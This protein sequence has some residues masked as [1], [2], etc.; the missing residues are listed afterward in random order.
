MAIYYITLPVL[1]T[2]DWIVFAGVNCPAM[3]LLVFQVIW[4]DKFAYAWANWYF[5]FVAYLL[6]TVYIL[7]Q[8]LLIMELK[9]TIS[10]GEIR[11]RTNSVGD[12][13]GPTLVNDSNLSEANAEFVHRGL[14]ALPKRYFDI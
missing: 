7:M 10:N 12:P 8:T 14:E 3:T 5:S 6:G 1:T 11:F 2:Q 4:Q 13:L 9:Q